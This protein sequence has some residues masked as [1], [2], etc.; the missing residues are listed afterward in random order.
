MRDV[1]T[2]HEKV[3]V[4][5]IMPLHICSFAN[6]SGQRAILCVCV[7]CVCVHVSYHSFQYLLLIV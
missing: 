7:V 6:I 1:V 3:N 2:V 5:V 4:C